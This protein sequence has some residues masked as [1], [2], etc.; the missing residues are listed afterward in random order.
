MAILEVS[1]MA[2]CGESSSLGVERLDFPL[3]LMLLVALLVV[4]VVVVAV[5]D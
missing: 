3:I 4:V 1:N 2:L 5:G